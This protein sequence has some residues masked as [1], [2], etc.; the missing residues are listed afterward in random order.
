VTIRAIGL[1]VGLDVQP[2]L[3]QVHDAGAEILYLA[4][5]REPDVVG[6]VPVNHVVPK[7]L[8]PKRVTLLRMKR[9][10]A[11]WSFAVRHSAYASELFP[12][13]QDRRENAR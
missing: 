1:T 13:T 5:L 4:A 6:E 2:V 11:D 12:T 9:H 8:R 10:G 7:Q 3:T